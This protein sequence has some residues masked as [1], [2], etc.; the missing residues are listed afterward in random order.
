MYDLSSKFNTFY[1]SYVVLPQTKQTNLHS[2]KDLNIQRLKDGLKEYNEEN[3]TAYSIV[4]TCVQGSVAMSTVVQNEDG[5]YD[6]DVAVVF[7]KSV[8]GDKGALSTRN[9]VA[10]ALKRKT[11]QFNT[12]PEVKTSCVRIK[13]ADG[14]HIDFAIYRRYYDSWNNCM[15]YE[16]AGS[17]WTKRDLRGLNDW[18][19][20]QNDN[21]DGKLRKVVRLSKMFCK[22]RQSWKNMPSGLLQ[23]VLCDEKLQMSYDRIDELFYYT[24]K[25]IVNRLDAND[26]VMAPVDDG[27]NLT[28]RNS[29]IQRMTNWRNRIKSKL[30]DLEI[31]FKVE[32]SE[33]DALQAWYG[34]FNHDYWN[35]KV[36]ETSNYSLSTISKSV[37]TF[38][39]NEEYIEELY[40]VRLSCYCKLSCIV[41]GNGWR[42]KR[43][44][45]FLSVL[46]R[47]LPHNFKIHCTMD[48]T[49][50][51][52]PYKIFWK[53]KNVG[54]DAAR[55]NQLRG[56]IVEKGK[57]IEE[58]SS[59]FGN[60]Y[61]ECYI[62]KNGVC[63]ARERINIPIGRG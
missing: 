3:K 63:V 61:I 54:P 59:F 10:N 21:S 18:F 51:T 7:D 24:M 14:Y 43:L 57:Y 6:I 19:K 29:D 53:V 11:K 22:S 28:P 56:Q 25:E 32:C 47:Y 42:P 35:E 13:Y 16:H 37:P 41:S 9:M 8:L 4:E 62:V 2:K 45:E 48:Y 58:R 52:P 1:N 17:E 5:D 60:H 55:R 40:P 20:T 49:N 44:N 30:E 12:E 50:C 39:D 46:R 38:V 36:F 33:S 23:T 27:R 15:V 26:S 31:L 34:F